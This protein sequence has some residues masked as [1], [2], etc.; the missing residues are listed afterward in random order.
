MLRAER[1]LADRQCAVVERPRSRKVALSLKQAGEVA[2]V[3][4]RFG[5]LGAVHLLVDRQRAVVERSRP[6]KVTL[7]MKHAGEVVE[8]RCRIGM[9]KAKRL[10][11]NRQRALVQRARLRQ[12]RERMMPVCCESIEQNTHTL[13]Q[14]LRW[15]GIATDQRKRKAV[16]PSRPRPRRRIVEDI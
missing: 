3:R 1:L 12:G 13:L 6:R 2:E 14:P 8:D 7:V 16:E 11:V 4:R 15:R 9:L 5:M 10:L